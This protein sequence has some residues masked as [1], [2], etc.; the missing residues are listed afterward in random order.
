MTIELYT[1]DTCSD[2]T[3]TKK[4]LEVLNISFT[5]HSIGVDIQVKDIRT[6]FPLAKR[7][8]VIVVDGNYMTT[9]EKVFTY[10]SEQ[11]ES[12]DVGKAA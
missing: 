3:Q 1:R 8:P 2:C 4:I 7:L 6:K 11:G 5:E 9:V 10:L 12:K